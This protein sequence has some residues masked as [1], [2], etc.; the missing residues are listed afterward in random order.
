MLS[1]IYCI[2]FLLDGLT[3]KQIAELNDLAEAYKGLVEVVYG[4][5]MSYAEVAKEIEKDDGAI[6]YSEENL[7]LVFR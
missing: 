2:V 3:N 4:I 6:R 7:I 1:F 5:R